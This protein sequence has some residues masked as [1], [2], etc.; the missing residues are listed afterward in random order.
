VILELSELL[1]NLAQFAATPADAG[2][3]A[4]LSD[5]REHGQ[6]ELVRRL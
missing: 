3:E 5:R 4:M 1:G 6:T 2:V